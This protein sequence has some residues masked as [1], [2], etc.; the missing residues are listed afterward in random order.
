MASLVDID[1]DPVNVQLVKF[2]NPSTGNEL[3][4]NPATG[5]IDI[6]STQ[7]FRVSF[8]L[9]NTGDLDLENA[10]VVLNDLSYTIDYFSLSVG[11]T[12]DLSYD[13]KFLSNLCA[14]PKIFRVTLTGP[15]Y[16]NINNGDLGNTFNY[17]GGPD[18]VPIIV[19][20]LYSLPM[21]RLTAAQQATGIPIPTTY[22]PD[23]PFIIDMNPYGATGIEYTQKIYGIGFKIKNPNADPFI[24]T[25][26][27]N[28][29]NA[30]SVP[31]SEA[32]CQK[33]G[34]LNI[35]AGGT[36][37]IK[38]DP[39]DPADPICHI[40]T[41]G[42][43]RIYITN[44]GV[45]PNKALS[46]FV[47]NSI[48]G[49]VT[50]VYS[51]NYGF[52]KSNVP[53]ADYFL[54]STDKTNYNPGEKAKI[55]VSFGMSG[56]HNLPYAYWNRYRLK[57]EFN[58]AAPQLP[59]GSKIHIWANLTNG[60][61][62]F[63]KYYITNRTLVTADDSRR[64]IA[65]YPNY[66]KSDGISFI[67][68]AF[69]E[70]S[71]NMPLDYVPENVTINVEVLDNSA[72][73]KNVGINGIYKNVSWVIPITPAIVCNTTNTQGV[74]CVCTSGPSVV[75]GKNI[76]LIRCNLRR[77][78]SLLIGKE[79]NVIFKFP[80]A[81]EQAMAVNKQSQLIGGDMEVTNPSGSPSIVPLNAPNFT[82]S[83]NFG[84]TTPKPSQIFEKTYTFDFDCDA[85]G[86]GTLAKFC[87]PSSLGDCV[88]SDP[89]I[90][91]GAPE[92][93][94]GKDND[95]VAAT[96]DGSGDTA[97]YNQPTTSPCDPD[98]GICA[99]TYGTQTCSAGSWV[100]DCAALIA[101]KTQT[102]DCSNPA[103][104]SDT[105]DNDC[106]GLTD[107]AGEALDCTDLCDPDHDGYY[108]SADPTYASLNLF[109]Q[110][111][112]S[113]SNLF[114]DNDC[115]IYD[116]AVNPGAEEVCDGIDNNCDGNIDEG[117]LNTYYQ[118]LDSD[119]FGNPSVSIS[120]CS[121]PA[122]YVSQ[123]DDCNDADSAINPSAAEICDG[124]DNNCDGQTDPV[125]ICE[126]VVGSPS[127]ACGTDVGEC[128][129]GLTTCTPT[130]WGSC[131]GGVSPSSEIM[132]NELD[133]D[134]NGMAELGT[135]AD[136]DGFK[137]EGGLCGPVDCDDSKATVNPGAAEICDGIDNDCDLSIDENVVQN[138]Y[139]QDS[140]SDGFGNPLVS[141]TGC[142]IPPGY[143]PNDDDCNDANA[144]IN[145][146]AA[147]ICD[148][149]IDENC[150]GIIDLDCAAGDNGLPNSIH[151]NHF[152]GAGINDIR[153]ENLRKN[154]NYCVGSK[155]N[156][157]IES[158]PYSDIGWNDCGPSKMMAPAYGKVF[159]PESTISFSW[160]PQ[161]TM[162]STPMRYWLGYS[163]DEGEHW[164]RIL[165]STT[166][167]SYNWNTVGVDWG[168]YIIKLI[169]NDGRANGTVNLTRISLSEYGLVSGTVTCN[170][171]AIEGA[172]VR[173]LGF[174]LSNATTNSAGNYEI[175][176]A[177][178]GIRTITASYE[179]STTGT[180]TYTIPFDAVSPEA[181]VDF[182]NVCPITLDCTANCTL[183]GGDICMADCNG[184]T[185]YDEDKNPIDTCN[186]NTLCVSPSPVKKGLLISNPD[187]FNPGTKLRC[188]EGE[189][190]PFSSQQTD[191]RLSE[192]IKADDV[193][194]T[195]RIVY[196]D[197]EPVK[198]IIIAWG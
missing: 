125:G 103:T 188:C 139:Y 148:N 189:I 82:A 107:S 106:D 16:L 48:D 32:L 193:I 150:N 184:F 91:P 159:K 151:L 6:G 99:G 67:P 192:D 142:I 118:D 71:F 90:Y 52:Y 117:V 3:S 97:R 54:V 38:I 61:I 63:N 194:R 102:E 120:A 87:D 39:A 55:F 15:F 126:C 31:A 158:I 149:N 177:P 7:V 153:A 195:T 174:P 1:P 187:P 45:T 68:P 11:Q 104:L 160:T 53:M 13:V 78:N 30:N 111:Y 165:E 136:Y 197:G 121:V 166:A 12:L 144:L 34:N 171:N 98:M 191:V 35:L 124:V 28:V 176:N 9:Q 22:K 96:P 137:I 115:Q 72:E 168:D 73:P 47:N 8:R 135:D 108:N 143:V 27:L 10:R 42:M 5:L 64:G 84:M 145:P 70:A 162:Y 113:V 50:G 179:G 74:G 170:G 112:C 141:Q 182:D 79:Y 134:C 169:P 163:S 43:W 83:I 58:P 75:D 128:E 24:G 105:L 17:A 196:Y 36:Q 133:E 101:A 123:S 20:P 131:M 65:T 49:S 155:G 18:C 186:L 29:N 109:Q 40:G 59:Q 89:A 132:C 161:S 44:T 76:Y 46:F 100:D 60:L 122:G 129:F 114:Q 146:L 140:D 62:I 116:P 183:R 154:V 93:C 178:T 198:M 69:E 175:H 185:E 95:C 152:Y 110:L 57:P 14:N 77:P 56:S 41:N 25:Y 37:D 172:D 138:T 190:V 180:G 147:E 130:G 86:D 94:D 80:Y 181:E 2:T 92:I 66:E 156:F 26:T 157:Y 4:V 119:S 21:D 81:L 85:D 88:D 167:N 173:V 19:A 51:A 33:T 23:S 127:Q 164:T